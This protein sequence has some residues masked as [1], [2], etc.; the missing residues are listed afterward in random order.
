MSVV[1][2]PREIEAKFQVPDPSLFARLVSGEDFLPGYIL[3]TT[4]RKAVLDTYVD[5]A[6]YKLLRH[7]FQ[8]RLRTQDDEQFATLKSRQLGDT[9]GIYRRLEIEE[10][11][12]P[13]ALP[14]A[15]DQ[16]PEPIW[17]ELTTLLAPGVELCP[18]CYLDQMRTTRPVLAQAAGRDAGAAEPM[19]A[20]LSLDEVRIRLAADAPALARQFEVEIELAPDVAE[21]ELQV[22]ADRFQKSFKLVPSPRSKLE[23]A[24]TVISRHP[25]QSPESWQGLRPEM[26]MAEAA[27]LIWQEQLMILLLNEAGVR[28]ADDPEYVHD[29]RVATRRAR[30]AARLY[31]DYFRARDIRRYLK[32]LRRTAQLL[33]AVRDLDVAIG[34]LDRY[35]KGSNR[36]TAAQLTARMEQWLAQRTVAQVELLAWLDSPGYARFVRSFAGFLRTPGVGAVDYTPQPGAEVTP[37]QVR[38][39]TPSMVLDSFERVRCYETWFEGDAEAPV[40]TLHQLRIACK[41]LRY[42]LEFTRS[43]LGP[44]CERLIASL[45]QLQD[46]LGDLNDAVVSKRMLAADAAGAA[47][48]DGAGVASYERAQDKLIRQLRAAAAERF[49]AFVAPENRRRLLQA[50]A[51]I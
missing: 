43:L 23:H 30:A 41:Y 5:T 14:Y 18:L 40:E 47:G 1:V 6:E 22:L 7:G 49:A 26:P 33:G 32:R 12:A 21:A 9:A 42:N 16:L 45:R 36:K 28:Y 24:L 3:G 25:L 19:L 48:A 37:H 29:M 31:G 8:L 27:R 4:Q 20:M 38:H 13:D 17:A 50:V 15:A 35:R 2:S 34:K 46:D 44:E 51:R 11:F 39:V 10:P